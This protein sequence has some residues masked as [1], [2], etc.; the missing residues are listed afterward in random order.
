MEFHSPSRAL[1][2]WAILWF[3]TIILQGYHRICLNALHKLYQLLESVIWL[4]GKKTVEEKLRSSFWCKACAG[5]FLHLDMPLKSIPVTQQSSPVDL[6]LPKGKERNKW[7]LQLLLILIQSSHYQQWPYRTL[8][9]KNKNN[10]KNSALNITPSFC[11][12]LRWCFACV[13]VHSN[14]WASWQSQMWLD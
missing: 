6:T 8:K 13:Y 1:P 12:Q 9:R 10:F 2:T 14:L 4:W 5:P 3:I 7:I 11:S